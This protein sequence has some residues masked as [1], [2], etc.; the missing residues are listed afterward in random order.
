MGCI[1]IHICLNPGK[2]TALGSQRLSLLPAQRLKNC[3]RAKVSP[4]CS[5][6]VLQTGHRA[7]PPRREGCKP[8]T[9]RPQGPATR[10]RR[11]PQGPATRGPARPAPH[12]QGKRPKPRHR[13]RGP[14]PASAPRSEPR[15]ARGEGTQPPACTPRPDP[16]T[17]AWSPACCPRPAG[18]TCPRSRGNGGTR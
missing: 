15:A 17:G 18:M 13:K 9:R 2:G 3:H 8:R 10:G 6:L 4:G 12:P 14:S 7:P 1:H 5:L 11:G 16:L